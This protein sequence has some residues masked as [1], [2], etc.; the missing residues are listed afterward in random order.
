M[1]SAMS[2]SGVLLIPSAASA[3][4]GRQNHPALIHCVIALVTM[5]TEIIAWTK[6]LYHEEEESRE[7]P[8][9]SS[10]VEK[11]SSESRREKV[12]RE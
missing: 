8:S 7:V 11:A 10:S 1:N 2:S 5:V 9:S 4:K 6:Y 3:Q 12:R